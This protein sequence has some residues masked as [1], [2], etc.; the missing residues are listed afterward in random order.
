MRRPLAH[1]LAVRRG[2]GRGGASAATS[3][4]RPTRRKSHTTQRVPRSAWMWTGNGRRLAGRLSG[5]ARGHRSPDS[6]SQP[7]EGQ[8]GEGDA[9]PEEGHGVLRLEPRRPAEGG[10]DG[11]AE[12][13]RQRA[14]DPEGEEPGALGRP[15]QRPGEGAR[16]RRAAGAPGRAPERL[17]DVD[18][19]PLAGRAAAPQ[20]PAPGARER[21]RPGVEPV[22]QHE[23]GA[24]AERSPRPERLPR[25]E[26][27]DQRERAGRAGRRPGGRPRNGRTGSR[28][29]AHERCYHR[30]RSA[31][32]R[33]RPRPRARART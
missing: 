11:P 7:P 31:G 27:E 2:A 6:G 3:H 20:A 15:A 5:R 29:Q 1:A 9:E 12:E 32:N 24:E 13:E 16:V 21:E 23:Q 30:T 8:D 10:G 33:S 26:P 25:E 28:G 17:V 18:P 22:R 4:Q 14:E 19:G